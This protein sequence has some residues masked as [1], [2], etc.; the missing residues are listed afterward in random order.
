MDDGHGWSAFYSSIDACER[1]V[2]H[3]DP[4]YQQASRCKAWHTLFFLETK[5][6]LKIPPYIASAACCRL[7][8]GLLEP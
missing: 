2:C 5:A 8:H 6:I 3:A 1:P 7:I 4:A